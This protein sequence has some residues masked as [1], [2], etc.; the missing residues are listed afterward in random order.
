MFAMN[1]KVQKK[2]CALVLALL[3]LM[4]G[5][6]PVSLLN[7]TVQNTPVTSMLSYALAEDAPDDNTGDEPEGIV[8]EGATNDQIGRAHV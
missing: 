7:S 8:P 3:L 2:A 5:T 4:Q 1:H 6:V